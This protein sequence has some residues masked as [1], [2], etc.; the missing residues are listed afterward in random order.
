LKKIGL[1]LC[2]DSLKC[3]REYCIDGSICHFKCLKVVRAHILGEVGTFCT[4]LLNVYSRTCRP[5]FTE[6]SLY[7][8][9]QN[10]LAC[11]LKHDV[12]SD[13]RLIT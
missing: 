3:T 7:L 12:Y 9:K 6:I 13:T 1:W 11:F 10:K 4:V 5:I 8:R 2:N